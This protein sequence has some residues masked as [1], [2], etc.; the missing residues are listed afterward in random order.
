VTS[1]ALLIARD[2]KLSHSVFALPFALLGAFL[3]RGPGVGWSEF[4]ASLVLVVGCMVSARTWAMVVNRLLDRDVDARNP[5]TAG[6]VF[7]S[8]RVRAWVGWAWA[9]ASAAVFISLCAVF[10]WMGNPWPL[11][12]SVPVLIWIGAY[13]LT[14]RFTWGCHLWLGASLAA[15]PI[16]AGV[17]V[18]P[19]SVGLGGEA[20]TWTIYWLS[21]MV[22]A[23]VAG[24][25]VIYALADEVFDRSEGLS[26]VPARLG[27]SGAMWVS[28][29]LHAGAGLLLLGAWWWDDRL[30]W[31]F[32][33]GVL[34]TWLLLVWEHVVVSRLGRGGIPVAFFTV[35]GVV[36]CVLGGAGIAD[37]LI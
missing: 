22:L 16:A 26:S 11:V 33:G 27:W 10:L 5:R 12:F 19:S 23:W 35:N 20:V 24:F 31:L 6:R 7:A 4:G 17:A 8:G 1:S 36:S 37:V 18:D 15:T 21:G 28:R 34:A 2:I 13:S 3:A 32:L 25:D 9:W 29:G 14:K 30:G